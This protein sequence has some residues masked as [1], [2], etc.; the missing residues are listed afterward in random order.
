MENRHASWKSLVA[1][2]VLAV[3]AVPGTA[4]LGSWAFLGTTDRAV[5]EVSNTDPLAGLGVSPSN[6]RAEGDSVPTLSGWEDTF[7]SPF[8]VSEFRRLRRP[9]PR[10]SPRGAY[11]F[12]F[13]VYFNGR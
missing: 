1:M 7:F 9:A 6:Q 13:F 10:P 3:V 5:A 12:A 8:A 4:V 2:L 11:S